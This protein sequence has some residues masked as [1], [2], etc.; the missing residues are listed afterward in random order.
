MYMIYKIDSN[1]N[2]SR[3]ICFCNHILIYTYNLERHNIVTYFYVLF[4]YDVNIMLNRVILE[5]DD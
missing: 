3:C 5:F 4:L 1:Y 2:Y